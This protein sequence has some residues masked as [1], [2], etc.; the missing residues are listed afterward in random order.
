MKFIYLTLIVTLLGACGST[1]EDNSEA[2]SASC[3]EAFRTDYENVLKQASQSI[4]NPNIETACEK[5]SASM[6][7][8]KAFLTA[9][10]NNAS[11]QTVINGKESTLSS[12]EVQKIQET[13][14]NYFSKNCQ[15]E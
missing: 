3:S 6:N 14:S 8:A 5:W 4:I 10:G 9:H 12:L 1:S 7:S 13:T 2:K 11:C 15:A